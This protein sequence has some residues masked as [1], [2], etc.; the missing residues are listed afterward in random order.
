MIKK[1]SK[2]IRG[3]NKGG[4]LSDEILDIIALYPITFSTWSTASAVKGA[5][6][7]GIVWFK[8]SSYGLVYGI[9]ALGVSWAGTTFHFTYEQDS[10]A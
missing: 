8:I 7:L 9:N 5:L 3:C 4:K 6:V 2:S 10:S 1:V